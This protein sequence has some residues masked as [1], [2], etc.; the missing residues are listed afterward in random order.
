MCLGAG[1]VRLHC[2]EIFTDRLRPEIF[3]RLPLVADCGIVRR[4]LSSGSQRGKRETGEVVVVNFGQVLMSDL[5]RVI[6]DR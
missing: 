1:E 4:K 3:C 6:G 5:R 2:L